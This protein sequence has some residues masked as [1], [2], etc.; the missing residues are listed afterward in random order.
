M[1]IVSNFCD[2][3]KHCLKWGSLMTWAAITLTKWVY[4]V[5]SHQS[6]QIREAF[7]LHLNDSKT[8]ANFC[9]SS[10]ASSRL[11]VIL[12]PGW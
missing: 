10:K 5:K 8:Y 12:T 9:S 7:E 3:N 4:S 6:S 11:I 2:F 1:E